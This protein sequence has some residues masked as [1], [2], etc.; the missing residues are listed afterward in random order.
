[1]SIIRKPEEILSLHKLKNTACRKMILN[2]L[3]ESK[4]AKTE[5][6]IKQTSSNLFDRVTFYRTLKTLEETG[7]IHSIVLGNNVV[8][9]ALSHL[10]RDTIHS[11]FHC[12]KCNNV[13][14]M[15]GVVDIKVNL[16]QGYTKQSLDV[17]INGIC[18]DCGS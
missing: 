17:I 15:H 7:I 8:K 2:E 12:A 10:E 14:C 11:H 9:Y 6:E 16:P 5:Q 1:M 13:Q 4:T 3:I 18:K